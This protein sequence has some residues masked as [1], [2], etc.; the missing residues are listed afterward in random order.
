MFIRVPAYG[1]FLLPRD[2]VLGEVVNLRI[3]RARERE[4]EAER[5]GIVK[6]VA[7]RCRGRYRR[8]RKN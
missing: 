5:R 8:V 2:R 3:T 7:G 1:S 6:K 4:R